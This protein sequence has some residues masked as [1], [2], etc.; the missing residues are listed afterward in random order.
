MNRLLCSGST[1]NTM[2]EGD[3]GGVGCEAEFCDVCDLREEFREIWLSAMSDFRGS[4]D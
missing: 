1:L 3:K 2:D 4:R